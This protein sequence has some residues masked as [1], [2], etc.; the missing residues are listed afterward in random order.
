MP[1]S[2]EPIEQ[3][4]QQ[5]QTDLGGDRVVEEC[6]SG[7]ITKRPPSGK[8][9]SL[10]MGTS[11]VTERPPY[12]RLRLRQGDVSWR[13]EDFGFVLYDRR[14]DGLY[15]GNQVGREILRRLDE[16]ASIDAICAALSAR[17]A[18]PPGKAASDVAE[19]IRFLVLEDLVVRW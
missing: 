4:S 15:E 2:T 14:T 10:A 3:A 9:T 19:F 11:G 12:E 16:G 8:W 7:R 1:K 18:V 5:S 17:Y 6:E 13:E